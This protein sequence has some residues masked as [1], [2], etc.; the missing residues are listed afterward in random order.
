M[1]DHSDTIASSHL[2]VYRQPRGLRYRWLCESARNPKIELFAYYR[3]FKGDWVEGFRFDGIRLEFLKKHRRI[4][5]QKVSALEIVP[6]R[7][8]HAAGHTQ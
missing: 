3:A 5:T 4:P 7:E 2:A 8:L 1:V 6:Q